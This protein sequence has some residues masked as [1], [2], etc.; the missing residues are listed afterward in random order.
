MVEDKLL[1]RAY[2]IGIKK[3]FRYWL[4]HVLRKNKSFEVFEELEC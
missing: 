1:N 3:D 2:N 4:K